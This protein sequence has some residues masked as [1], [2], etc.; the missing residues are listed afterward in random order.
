M[1]IGSSFNSVRTFNRFS[2][3]TVVSEDYWDFTLISS[4]AS[5]MREKYRIDFTDDII[6]TD[7]DLKER[8]FAAGFE[9]LTSIGFYCPDLRRS[10]SITADDI[11]NG[12]ENAPR[13]V[14]VGSGK[15]SRTLESRYGNVRRKPIVFGGPTATVVSEDIYTK[16]MQSYAQEPIVD[17]LFNGVIESLEGHE[18]RPGSPMEMY[19]V[20]S[21]IKKTTLA[22]ISCGRPGMSIMGPES[23]ITSSSRICA[24]L[25]AVGFDNSNILDIPQRNEMK[26]DLASL[27]ML[28]TGEMNG[29]TLLVEQLPI[30]GGYCG[31]VEETAICDVATTLASF[32][33]MNADIHVDGPI[34]LRWGVTTARECLQIAGHVAAAI[35]SNASLLL[36]N[37]YYVGAGPCTEMCFMENAAQAMT[38][39]ASGREA[40]L[41]SASAKGVVMDKTTGMEPRFAG[42]VSQA[43]AGLP[44]EE[45]NEILDEV[46]KMYE[47]NFTNIPEGK[48]FQDCYDTKTMTPTAEHIEV[49]NRSIEKLRGLG[50][51]IRY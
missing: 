9:M 20:L 40:I 42:K 39:T 38:D 18:M 6:P 36:G 28:A 10:L 1:G 34:H 30:F 19:A 16:M 2:N 35:E 50:L 31:G 33:I 4:T 46:V 29:Y 3:G 17:V 14:Q 5:M 47:S 12:I 15:E 23:A 25:P 44:V 7:E 49:Y 8:L 41:S 43:V 11:W 26:V 24:G 32:T 27:N 37:M 22:K 51:N 48:R 21:E 13:K 45:V